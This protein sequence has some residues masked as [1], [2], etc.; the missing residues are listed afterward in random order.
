MSQLR[1]SPQ[2]SSFSKWQCKILKILR[3]VLNKIYLNMDRFLADADEQCLEG[4]SV[5]L[6]LSVETVGFLQQ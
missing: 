2:F 6:Q 3:F 1:V 5:G 4:G